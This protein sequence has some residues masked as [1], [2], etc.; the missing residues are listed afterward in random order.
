MTALTSPRLTPIV[1]SV[2]PEPPVALL[3]LPVGSPRAVRDA[4]TA[5]YRQTR[6]GRRVIAVSS[7]P[8]DQ[9]IRALDHIGVPAASSQP[10]GPELVTEPVVVI[11]GAAVTSS[12]PVADAP[13]VR[14]A[15][16]GCGVVGGGVYARLRDDP[17]FEITAVLVRNPRRRR[18]PQPDP[19]R[20]VTS[21]DALLATG[22]DIV[23]DALSDADAG[24]LLT[25]LA[26][27][28]GVSV[29]S[30]NKQAVGPN[31]EQLQALAVRTGATLGLSACV[32]GG[33]PLIETLQRAL[34][35]APVVK[36]EAVLNGT[37]NFLLNRL[38]SGA[39]FADA[40]SE[41]R[42]AG[43]AEADPSADLEGR[44][45]A[46][47]LSILSDLAFGCRL[48]ALSVQ[49]LSAETAHPA[50]PVR[51]VARAD[52]QTATIAFEPV[53]HDLLLA[54]LPDEWNAI[55]VTC[56]DGRVFTARGRGAGR[57]P[58]AESVWSDLLD[59]LETPC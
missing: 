38:S 7:G 33:A 9:L 57:W 1:P 59:L 53:A 8:A 25:R 13:P 48:S 32:G 26:L 56:E 49:K 42:I 2:Q 51:Q 44:D 23:L 16:A 3:H 47:K 34:D 30:A 10:H 15:L 35:H 40:L 31:L 54:D 4:A 6:Q 14:V 5:V 12:M 58:T 24:H 46:A 37:V 28:R 55:R 29:V 52:G 17:R 41:T 21:L 39:A 50:G 19:S 36:I 20:L 27:A 43:F 18:D 22:P 45:A 11:E